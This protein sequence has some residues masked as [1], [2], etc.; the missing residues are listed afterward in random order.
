MEK[1]AVLS[2]YM[3]NQVYNFVHN[4]VDRKPQQELLSVKNRVDEWCP[5]EITA[6]EENDS[7]INSDIEVDDR[8]DEKK[9]RHITSF[10]L[11]LRG[12][13]D[14][15]R[16]ESEANLSFSQQMALWIQQVEENT[17]NIKEHCTM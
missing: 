17:A 14:E 1:T 16:S 13:Q 4:V 12:V 6:T 5:K 7:F 15:T 8:E 2:K 9:E 3:K 11:D 10:Q